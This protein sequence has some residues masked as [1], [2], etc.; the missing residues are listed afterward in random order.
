MEKRAVLDGLDSVLL[1]ADEVT[2]GGFVTTSLPRAPRPVCAASL[3]HPPRR[4]IME[5]DPVAIVNRVVMQGPGSERR[6][7]EW[8]SLANSARD[9]FIKA[10]TK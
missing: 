1:A 3:T 6:H 10:F 7:S 9:T 8:A 2:D 5:T 4:V